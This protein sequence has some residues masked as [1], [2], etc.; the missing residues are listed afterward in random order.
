MSKSCGP[1]EESGGQAVA[2]ARAVVGEELTALIA[3]DRRL[4][5]AARAVGV[6]VATPGQAAAPEEC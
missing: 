6:V 1:H 2:E 4:A 5:G 3:Y